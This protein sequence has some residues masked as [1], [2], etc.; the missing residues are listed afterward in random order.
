MNWLD[1]YYRA[2]EGLG[3]ANGLSINGRPD[4]EAIAAWMFDV[5]LNARLGP[6]PL[7]KCRQNVMHAIQQT[8]EWRGRHVN[9]GAALAVAHTPHPP[10]MTFDRGEFLRAL[11]RLDVFYRAWNG[12][13]RPNGLSRNAQPDFEGIA[14][15]VFDVYLNQRDAGRSPEQAWDAVVAAIQGSNEWRSKTRTPVDATTLIGKHLV[16]YQ[17]WFC[18]PN[19]GQNRGWDH[20][21]RNNAPSGANAVF[22]LWP[23]TREYF[24]SELTATGMTL[25][26]GQPA[27]LYSCGN[28]RT[29]TRQF[30][31]MAD[32][33][34]DGVSIGRFVDGTRDPV[35]RQRLDGVLDRVRR[36]AESTGRVFFVWYDITG[37]PPASFVNDV[38]TDWT[39]LRQQIRIHQS[40][41]Y[42]HHGGKPIVGLWAAGS[43]T[44]PPAANDWIA[45]INALK[46]QAP[47][48]NT[49]LV[50]TIRDW[51]VNNTWRPVMNVADIVA[52]WAVTGCH[53][54]AS[55]DGFC[56]QI[57]TPDIAYTSA[58][59]Q[60]Y[61]PL[62]FPGFS[63]HNL[64]SQ[65]ATAP[66]NSTPRL[67][68]RFYWRQAHNVINSGAQCL[69]TAMFDEVDEGTACAKVA[70][71]QQ[72]VPNQGSFLSLDAEGQQLPSDWYL[73]LAGAAARMLRGEIAVTPNIPIIP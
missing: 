43:G 9:D 67:G 11:H 50:S 70:T 35:T 31:W 4:F 29:V 48:G 65:H 7:D 61:L 56:Q 54:E 41:S 13:Q 59:Q 2:P 5:F 68:G 17:G 72:D 12:L 26:T 6:L 40:P 18:T 1:G 64:Q 51:R 73:R 23:D 27:R 19:D 55:A 38:L 37:C 10:R 60:V 8:P 30:D 53:D 47:G 62:I 44:C 36:A 49:V 20:W 66:L 46:V 22:D 25:R 71:T 57:V 16:G 24:D 14:A 39:Y 69:F 63:W 52:P 3:R 33:G 58:R 42:L 28:Q 34:I 45:L 32:V 15:W 21:F